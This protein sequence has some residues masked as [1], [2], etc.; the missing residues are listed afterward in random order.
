MPQPPHVA[1][2]HIRSSRPRAPRFQAELDMLNDAALEALAAEGWT[3]EL[4]AVTERPADEV[5]RIAR[6]ADVVLVMGGEDVDPAFYGGR[7]EYPGSGIH[8]PEA[9]RITFDIMRE[10]ITERRPLLAIC[11]GVQQL[12]VALGG[13]IHEHMTGHVVP[14]DD[15][16][17]L[18]AV[19]AEADTGI[20]RLGAA[21]PVM[22]SHH[23]AIKEV[24]DGLRVTARASDGT[25]EA[26]EH[27]D[28]PVAG[29]QWHP[30]HPAV[31]RAQL[32]PLV[33]QLLE[34][35]LSA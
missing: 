23:Q 16:F 31:A 32:A 33:R 13:T 4:V 12:N 34:R 19:H 21:A 28:A 14:A 1:V 17:V 11:R 3:T 29:V 22:C 5:R 8:E 15:P 25:V 30:E 10:A 6:A 20:A 27:I 24:A 2:L 9:D 26:V 7:S 35:E 18:T